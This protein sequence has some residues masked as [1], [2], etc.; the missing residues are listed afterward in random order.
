MTGYGYTQTFRTCPREVWYS[1]KF[2]RGMHPR[3]TSQADPEATLVLEKIAETGA[4]RAV[5]TENYDSSRGGGIGVSPEGRFWILS[6]SDSGE[7]GEISDKQMPMMTADG[8]GLIVAVF[9]ASAVEVVEAF[10]IILAMGITRGWKSAIAGTVVALVALG[11]VTA[12]VGVSLDRY[13]NAAFLQFFIGVL[14]LI[15]GAQWLRKAILRSAGL[16]ALHDE[17]QIFAEEQAAARSAQ[18]T[19]HFGIDWF[20]FVVTFKGVLLEGIEVIF[21]VITFGIGAAHRGMP[22]AMAIAATG[23]LAAAVM[24]MVA[25]F[26]ARRPLS[27]VPENTMKFGVGLLLST[28]GIFWAV[29]GMRFFGPEK[30]SLQ[31]PGGTWALLYVLIAWSVVSWSTVTLLRNTSGVLDRGDAS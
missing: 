21:I 25:G 5:Q 1:L 13:V 19:R 26:F 20:G 10:T 29:E 8:A 17:E 31:W 7:P 12:A 30:A 11:V 27:M 16:K 14:L 2:G 3:R 9:I 22:N 15:F 4:K 18:T 24:V 6:A 28:F 23:A